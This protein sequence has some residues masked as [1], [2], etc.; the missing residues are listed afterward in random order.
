MVR[1]V[2]WKDKEELLK[3][4]LIGLC[5]FLGELFRN[6]FLSNKIFPDIFY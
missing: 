5:M 3:K 6:K 1:N 4:Q 2:D